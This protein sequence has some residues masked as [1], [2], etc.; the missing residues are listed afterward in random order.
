[1]ETLNE[2]QII[3]R[4]KLR[5]NA[6]LTNLQSQLCNELKNVNST[7]L[8]IE[9]IVQE[10]KKAEQLLKDEV[11]QTKLNC[12]NREHKEKRDLAKKLDDL[13]VNFELPIND[14]T[15]DDFT[16]HATKIKKYPKLYELVEDWSRAYFC[17]ENLCYHKIKIGKYTIQLLRPVYEN[18]TTKYEVFETFDD[19]LY[20]NG[21]K[22]KK[23]TLKQVKKEI[24]KI[25]KIQEKMQKAQDK[26]DQE[27]KNTDQY[28][29]KR[30]NI[31]S[32]QRKYYYITY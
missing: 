32:Q 25:N 6:R 13:R 8:S 20:H 22:A 2:N 21:I 26:F 10:I 18:R 16:F 4:R 3:E 17:G 23:L 15:N 1:M 5:L 30:E 12:I 11:L 7:D 19:L 31:L 9:E 27:I 24:S 29:L 14:I 28:F